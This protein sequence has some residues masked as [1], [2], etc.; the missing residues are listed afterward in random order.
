M[1]TTE[2]M[3]LKNTLAERI[4]GHM[5]WRLAL[6]QTLP[7]MSSG[8]FE[9][10]G[11]FFWMSLHSWLI[12][13]LLATVW[14]CAM[15]SLLAMCCQWTW[16]RS[17]RGGH[18]CAS[19]CRGGSQAWLWLCML[20]NEA[21]AILI[22]NIANDWFCLLRW[23]PGTSCV[24]PTAKNYGWCTRKRVSSERLMVFTGL[25]CN[26]SSEIGGVV[27]VHGK[28]ESQQTHL[29]LKELALKPLWTC[30]ILQWQEDGRWKWIV[31]SGVLLQPDHLVYLFLWT[32]KVALA[33]LQKFG[34][35]KHNLS[36]NMPVSVCTPNI[37][38]LYASHVSC[39][40]AVL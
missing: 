9:R 17:C 10:S 1:H 30:R 16:W 29:D 15:Q 36:C 14:Y 4:K 28:F 27:P 18:G 12:G 23:G 31:L 34:P 32:P 22:N 25:A 19:G 26:C 5:F 20:Q 37:L 2:S 13:R 3:A 40:C 21:Q 8:A 39:W 35:S 33:R 6:C 7:L 38:L 11:C 24:S